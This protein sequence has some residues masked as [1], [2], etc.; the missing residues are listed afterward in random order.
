M[1]LMALEAL[2]NITEKQSFD[3]GLVHDAKYLYMMLCR[4]HLSVSS[5]RKSVGSF[6]VSTTTSTN[7]VVVAMALADASASLADRRQTTLLAVFVDWLGDPVDSCIT[8]D[9]LVLRINADDFKVLVYC[10][11]IHPV[12]VKHAKISASASYTLLGSLTE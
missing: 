9:S 5:Q 3:T 12:R 1:A 6:P 8:S 4:I 7:R 11:L 10:V 2:V